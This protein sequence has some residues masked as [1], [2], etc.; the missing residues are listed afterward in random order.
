MQVRFSSGGDSLHTT[1]I[2]SRRLSL[3]TN[4]QRPLR[5]SSCRRCAGK[6]WRRLMRALH[7]LVLP[8]MPR[9]SV[10]RLQFCLS[11]S[12]SSRS[13]QSR[14]SYS[15]SRSLRFGLSSSCSSCRSSSSSLRRGSSKSRRRSSSKS[16]SNSSL[17]SC[18]C[19]RRSCKL[20][21]LAR[22][23]SSDC[24]RNVVDEAHGGHSTR[25]S[26][27]KARF[28]TAGNRASCISI[29]RSRRKRVASARR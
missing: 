10:N 15:R 8:Q 5:A 27:A 13:S 3:L 23:P 21:S 28:T 24:V 29:G 18:N 11:S 7:S 14:R 6:S 16:S 2:R 17:S 1:F 20:H 12:C 4:L 25:C 22:R 9:S 19:H 26:P